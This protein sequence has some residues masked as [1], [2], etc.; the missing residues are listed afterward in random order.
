VG[1]LEGQENAVRLA[2]QRSAECPSSAANSLGQLEVLIEHGADL[3]SHS[4]LANAPIYNQGITDVALRVALPIRFPESGSS[5]G[6]R[7]GA[8]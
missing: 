6:E 7:R 3:R 2:H 5:A 8:I 1:L 4:L